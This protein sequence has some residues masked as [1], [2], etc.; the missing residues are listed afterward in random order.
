MLALASR[1]P[2]IRSMA[3]WARR[4]YKILPLLICVLAL[5]PSYVWAYKLSA[6]SESPTLDIGAKIIVNKAAYALRLPYSNL[7]LFRVRSPERGE[8]VLVRLPN[9]RTV[10]PKRVMGLP[11]ET[12]EF[13]ENRIIINGRELPL[14]PLDRG[15]FDWVSPA[16]HLGS[17]VAEEE[18]HRISYTPGAGEYRNYPP[19]KLGPG[20]YFVVGD[21]RDVSADSRIWGALPE[22]SILGKVM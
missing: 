13:R 19:L 10:A 21:N 14:R 2:Y 1:P 8:M 15:D 12:I 6:P 7:T 20:L 17:V 4:S 11:G 22:S 9:G 3:S 16:N 18:G 5:L